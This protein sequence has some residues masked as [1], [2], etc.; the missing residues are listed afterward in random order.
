MVHEWPFLNDIDRNLEIEHLVT[1]KKFIFDEF[2]FCCRFVLSGSNWE[3]PFSKVEN[4]HA[5]LSKRQHSRPDSLRGTDRIP[6]EKTKPAP[7][8][9]TQECRVAP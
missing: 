7:R 6:A 1:Q 9:E 2:A 8:R 4:M 5:T 3:K